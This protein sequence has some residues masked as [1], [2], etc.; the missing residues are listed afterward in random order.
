MLQEPKRM[1]LRCSGE[2]LPFPPESC[3]LAGAGTEALRPGDMAHKR[4]H[5]VAEKGNRLGFGLEFG[6]F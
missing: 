3:A 6:N 4:R 5:V 2:H 1:V